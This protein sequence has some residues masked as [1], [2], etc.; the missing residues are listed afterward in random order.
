MTYIEA[1]DYILQQLP[2]FTR[3]GGAAYKAD[4]SR[5]IYL[6][7]KLGNPHLAFR[8]IHIA[9]TNGK[10]SIASFLAS[11]FME[12][13]A[14]TALFTS[15]H[16]RDFRER[17]T[18]NGELIPQ[19]F[20]TK[21][22][23]ENK[24]S[25]EIIE[26][27][28]FEMSFALAAKWFSEQ[29]VDIAIIETGMGGRLD[30]TNVVMPELSIITNIG[31]DHQQFLGSTLAQIAREKAGIIKPN[32]PVV[33]GEHQPETDS[34]FI[35]KAFEANASI[36]WAD[37]MINIE[38]FSYD[39]ENDVLELRMKT[40]SGNV[41]DLNSPL[42]AE[43]ET[44]NIKTVIAAIEVL[45]HLGYSLTDSMIIDGIRNVIHHTGLKGRWQI[46]SKNPLTVADISHNEPGIGELMK[47]VGKMRYDHLHF[48]L[49]MVSDKDSHAILK[50]LPKEATYY[51][52][53]PNIPRGK[54]A[55]QL[56]AEA[57]EFGLHGNVYSS[58]EEAFSAAS[59]S[60]SSSDMILVSGSAF[61]VAEIV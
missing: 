31:L 61:V 13:G 22:I 26:P 11:I 48:V 49:G 7:E 37:E 14:K 60:A 2:M 32:I 3:I 41:F 52:C 8:S 21:F 53:R 29:K 45:K 36:Y 55:Y 46:L 40:S 5:T 34:V 35:E 6:C 38:N 44:K 16:L 51:F 42:A 33:I 50:L 1:V 24:S 25:F 43:Y 57:N 54:D 17:I 15:P 58:V 28:F 19:D 12:S 30:S 47:Q 18:I 27:S 20:V 39:F 4:L 59:A 23:Q 10:G 56:A 9:G